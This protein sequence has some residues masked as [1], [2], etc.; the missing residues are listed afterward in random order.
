MKKNYYFVA[1]ALTPLQFGVQ[2]EMSFE[3]FQRLLEINLTPSDYAKTQTIRRYYDIENIRAFWKGEEIDPRG[4]L[5]EIELE[6]ALLSRDGLPGYV[7]DFID[8]YDSKEKR[9]EHFAS[10]ITSFFREESKNADGLLK[11]YLQFERNW[12][13]VLLGFRAKKL[14]KDLVSALQFEDPEDDLVAQILA[15]K[16]AKSFVAPEGYED[17]QSIFETNA[18][19]PMELHIALNQYRYRKV[20]EMAGVELFSIDR[21]LGYMVRLIIVEKTIELDKKKGLEIMDKVMKGK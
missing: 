15:Q 11:E 6:E 17:L 10:L 20:E 5:Y 13:L 21:I 19:D 3:E 8:A 16:D 18:D 2:P 14:G 7:Y 12:R 9:L 4:S 1:T